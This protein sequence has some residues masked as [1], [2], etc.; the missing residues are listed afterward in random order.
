MRRVSRHRPFTVSASLSHR[1]NQAGPGPGDPHCGHRR[2]GPPDR[3][4]ARVR[5]LAR[6]LGRPPDPGPPVPRPDRVREPAGDRW[7]WS[8]PWRPAFL[9]A[10]FRAPPAA[11]PDLAERRA[12]GG[13]PGPGRARRDRGATPSST[14]TW[15]W[16]TSSP[17]WSCW[18]TPSSWSTARPR[19]YSPGSARAPG[20]PAPAPVPVRGPDPARRS[21]SRPGRPPP[22]PDHSPA[23]RR[24]SRW[25]SASR[26]P[27]GT[28][29]SSTPAWPCSWS[30]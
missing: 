29:P 8:S 15:S 9:A 27:S 19:D 21:S 12:G 17:P 26:S 30:A 5:R 24:A 11:G 1:L 25:P 20:A 16:C 23:T 10:V 18:P 14:P 4:G 22:G 7:S 2:G 3:V 28:W 13:D 6:L